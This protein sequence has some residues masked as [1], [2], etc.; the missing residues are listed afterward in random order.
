MAMPRVPAEPESGLWTFDDL[1]SLPDDG[2]RYEIIH[3]ELIPM[4]MGALQHQR[5]AA[6]LLIAIN[7]WCRANGLSWMLLSPGGVYVT[8][9]TWL[10]PDVAVY[11]T[12]PAADEDWKRLV[13]PVLVIEVLSPSTTR[14]DRHR[15]RPIYL[16]HG[17]R[18]VW[19]VDRKK[20]CIERWTAASEFPVVESGTVELSLDEGA[21]PFRLATDE[22]FGPEPTRSD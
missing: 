4:E 13:A 9:T 15:K 12:N 3:G 14:H 22:L 8:S 1:E 7:D 19:L 17:V 5:V 16:S 6:T 18:E 21:A 11:A 20:R 10:V 2:V